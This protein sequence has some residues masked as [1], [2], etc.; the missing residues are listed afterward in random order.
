MIAGKNCDVRGFAG[1][2]VSPGLLLALDRGGTWRQ[3]Q[4]LSEIR[5][6]FHKTI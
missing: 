5:K 4:W 2:A 1:C 3:N 6:E